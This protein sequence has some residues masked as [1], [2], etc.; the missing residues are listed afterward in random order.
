MTGRNEAELARG[1]LAQ[2]GV[3][4]KTETDQH[5]EALTLCRYLVADMGSYIRVWAENQLPS[6]RRSLTVQQTERGRAFY[7][8]MINQHESAEDWYKRLQA[9]T[10]DTAHDLLEGLFEAARDDDNGPLLARGFILTAYRR[11]A[12][13]RQTPL[14]R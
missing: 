4:N 12:A 14:P 13:E 10:I 7:R 2:L 11:L 8:K 3:V 5:N 1:T 6:Y 9:A